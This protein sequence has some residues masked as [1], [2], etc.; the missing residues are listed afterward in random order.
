MCRGWACQHPGNGVEPQWNANPY[1]P[2][3]RAVVRC[4]YVVGVVVRAVLVTP[5][6]GPL[7]R[8]GKAGALALALWADRSGVRLE[9]I[10]A[11]PSA[12]SAIQAAEA[13]RPDVLFG[14]YGSGPALAAAAASKGV[15]WNHGGAT[16]RLVRPAYPRV[17][18]VESPAYRYLAAV[19]ETLAADGLGEGSEVVIMHVDT[20]FGRE[21]AEGAAMAARRLGLPRRSVSFRPGRARDVLAQVP[22][23]DV[24]LSAGSFDDDIAIAQWDSEHRWRTVG[25][26]AAGVD[27]LRHAI[28]DRVE[29][30]YGP[31]QWF[32]DGTDHP[33]DGPNSAWFS[34]CYR[35][36][37]GAE[38]PYP[39]AAAFAAGVL[40]QRCVKVAGTVES[41]PV[42]AA[43]Q[44]LDTTTLFGRF[45]VDPVTGVQ[46]GHQIRVVRWRDG[47]RVVV[48]RPR[49][50]M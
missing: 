19:L 47:Q 39:A 49:R 22:A 17:V 29:G 13:S 36:A 41:L 14:P 38:P 46:T 4:A 20:G 32:D 50:R 5:L 23:G 16:A 26:V 15:L 24:L 12:A 18:N 2:G 37:N 9:V 8:F 44:R 40:W 3:S 45:R 11:Y 30:L 21:V 42:L 25:L 27:D 10:D 35:D 7:A 34:Q 43:S 48:D 6:S 33:A 28:G 31:C 1:S